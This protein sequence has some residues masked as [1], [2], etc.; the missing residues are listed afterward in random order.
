MGCDI[1]IYPERHDGSKW[2]PAE[3]FKLAK[4]WWYEQ[5]LDAM[6]FEYDSVEYRDAEAKFEA[7]SEDDAIKEYGDNPLAY[8]DNPF[9]NEHGRR[10]YNFF[11]VLANVRSSYS[12][13]LTPISKC[14][15]L[16]NDLSVRIADRAES[17][18]EDAHSHSWYTLKELLDYDWW[19]EIQLSGYISQKQFIEFCSG[20]IPDYSL[21]EAERLISN[22]QMKNVCLGIFNELDPHTYYQTEV[23]WMTIRRKMIGVDFLDDFLAKLKSYG[24]PE[25]VRIIFWFDN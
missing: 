7:L 13:V 25:N 17:E 15:G 20:K 10:N 8:W 19:R 9:D 4:S 24:D 12:E 21:I 23:Q 2:V 6:E 14:K 11:T 16:P 1:H 18:A 3:P 5:I 22:E